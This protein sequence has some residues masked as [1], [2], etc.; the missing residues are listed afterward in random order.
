MHCSIISIGQNLDKSILTFM[1]CIECFKFIM[2]IIIL[3]F[4]T[5]ID[6]IH[7]VYSTYGYIYITLLIR[8]LVPIPSQYICKQI[9]FSLARFYNEISQGLQQEENLVNVIKIQFVL[10]SIRFMSID[11]VLSVKAKL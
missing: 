6:L 5:S 3:N 7:V 11:H 9:Y 10:P 8:L 2:A 1:F 4:L